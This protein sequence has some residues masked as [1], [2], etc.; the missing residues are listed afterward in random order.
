MK[1]SMQLSSSTSSSFGTVELSSRTDMQS[2]ETV[3]LFVLEAGNN[4]ASSVQ[5]LKRVAHRS[6]AS[7]GI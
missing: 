2:C 5:P 1:L 7:S 3:Y 4:N 6:V